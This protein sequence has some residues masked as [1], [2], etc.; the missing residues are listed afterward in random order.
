MTEDGTYVLLYTQWNRKV[1]RLAVA[2]S[3]DLKHWTK[4]G[5][6]F[7]KAYNGKFKDEATKSA[8]LVTTLKGDKQVIA[9]V[10]GKYFMYWGEK[11]VYA[12]TSDNLTDWDPL[13]DEN[14]E[15]LKLFSPRSG[16]FDSQLTECGPPAIL[17]RMASFCCITVKTNREKRG[18]RLSCELLLCRTS[19][20]R[21]K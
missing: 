2:T 17:T 19:I 7:E 11:N 15:L 8:S 6:A 18:Y 13:L 1:P 10:N 12:A 4:F 21:C 9:K 3:K 14:G 5:P 20:V 16:Y